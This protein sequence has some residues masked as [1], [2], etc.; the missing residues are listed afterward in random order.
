MTPAQ[1]ELLAKPQWYSGIKRSWSPADLREAYELHNRLTGQN[2]SDS[3]C[4]A[5]RR[6]V[7]QTLQHQYQIALRQKQSENEGNLG[8]SKY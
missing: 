7:I 1:E 4:N 2:K 6:A 3:G 8:T 5:C